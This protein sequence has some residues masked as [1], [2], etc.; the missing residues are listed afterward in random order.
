MI[1]NNLEFRDAQLRTMFLEII[2]NLQN[3]Q[4]TP[5][6]SVFLATI[7]FNLSGNTFINCFAHLLYIGQETAKHYSG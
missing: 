2:L 7:G 6:L 1:W 5:F 4:N 3:R